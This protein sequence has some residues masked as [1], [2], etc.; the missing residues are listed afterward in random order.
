MFKLRNI[1]ILFIITLLVSCQTRSNDKYSDTYTSGKIK[2]AIDNN[3][4]SIMTEELAVFKSQFPQTE[5]VP[6]YSNELGAIDQMMKDSARVVIATRPLS[7]KELDYL[8]ES[9]QFYPKSYKLAIDGI[10]VIANKSNPD[11]L[12][13]IA[14]LRRILTGKAKKW[15]DVYPSSRLGNLKVVF[16]DPS[17]STVRYAIDSICFGAGISKDLNAQHSNEEVINYVSKTPNAIGIIGVNWLNNAKDTT[18]LSFISSVR[19]MSLTNEQVATPENS[20]KPYQAYLLDESYPLIRTIYVIVNDPR[21]SL[22]TTVST[23]LTGDRGQRII[24]KAGLVPATQP[25]R[26]VEIKDESVSE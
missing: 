26:I 22:P 6:V 12:L 1:T 3:F 23:F 19:V 24:L 5:I 25:V 4:K 15:K 13:S 14:D 11:T 7:K 21:G 18:R 16:D 17:S 9:K 2:V 10:A 8:K 20:Y